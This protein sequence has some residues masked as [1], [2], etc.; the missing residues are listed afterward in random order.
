MIFAPSNTQNGM[1]LKSASHAF[2]RNP[3]LKRSASSVPE[4]LIKK[5]GRN[6]S[7]STMLVAGPAA[8]IRPLCRWLTNP[9]MSTA[10]GAAITIP[11]NATT[12]LSTSMERL[13]LNSA[14]LL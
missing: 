2:T 4:L 14:N 1:R 5:S 3:K 6:M 8:L 7:A 11:L 9:L 12:I 10:P 13:A